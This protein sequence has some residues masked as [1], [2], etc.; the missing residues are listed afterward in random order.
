M[1]SS[2]IALLL[3]ASLASQARTAE[4]PLHYDEPRDFRQRT[5]LDLYVKT[6]VC[7]GDAARAI[8]REGVREPAIVQHFMVSMCGDPFRR[9]LQ[10]D[11]M[12]E[13][14]ARRTL[15]ALTRQALY[16]DVLHQPLPK[17]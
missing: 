11:G 14:T 10:Q 4:E 8:L 2:L 13:E 15:V 6:R 9:Q 3:F 7:L 5:M 1:R 12:S 16:E 17:D